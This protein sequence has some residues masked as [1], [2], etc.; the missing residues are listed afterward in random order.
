MSE[1]L[2]VKMALIGLLGVGAQWVAWRTGRPAI[3]L[4]LIAGIIA[5]PVLGWIVPERDFGDLQEPIIKLAVAVI[6]FAAGLSL[7]FRELRHAGPAVLR[8]MVIGVPVGALLGTLAAHYAAGLPLG[9][10][11]VFGGIMVVTGPTVIGPMLR[12]LRVPARTRDI[13]K[14][15]GIVNDP[16]GA[17][18]GA[19]IYGYITYAGVSRDAMAIGFDMA[20]AAAIAV[21]IGVALGYAV[22]TLFPRGYVP[23]FLMAP[24]LLV[25]VI[26]GFVLADVIKHET[27]LITVTVMG[28]VMANRPMYSSIALRRF[29]EDLAVLLISGVFIILSATLDYQVIAHFRLRFVLF[30][31]LL[32]FAIR[33][34]TVLAS[35]AFSAVPWRERLFVAW[36]A[37]RGIVAVAVTGLFSLRLADLGFIGARELQS[38][39]FAVVIVT[40]F[41]HSFSASWWA[42]RLGI[43]QGKELDVLLIG[44]NGWTN[45]FGSAL[46][47]Y[48]LA[49]TVADTSKFALRGARK[50]ELAVHL[51]D[52]LDEATQSQLDMGRFQ[53]VIAATE[54]D[55]YNALVCSDL[56]PELGVERLA[57]TGHDEDRPSHVRARVLLP[58]GASI[59]A[60][61]ERIAAGWTFSRTRITEKFGYDRFREQLPEGAEPVAL[62]DEEGNLLLFSTKAR[63]VIE[64]G[65]SVIAFYPPEPPRRPPSRSNADA[66]A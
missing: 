46:K 26:G 6:L 12:T 65:D 4:M 37:P 30:L 31:V 55:A 2:M 23:E 51:G 47:Q 7:N 58:S 63:P 19:A 66:P 14:W 24:V 50:H 32:L 18:L 22:T 34:A 13:L 38:L 9:I 33:P 16:I 17:L 59:E 15:E 52:V 27:G 5:G 35:L 21:A 60:L 29:K 57:Q 36:I 49:V 3:V 43:D 39:G 56:G 8:L 28:V 41:A 64:P 48:G 44:A 53:Q 42:R 25:T 45:A 10:S 40:I 11:A 61:E 62:L 1:S 20:G 54:N